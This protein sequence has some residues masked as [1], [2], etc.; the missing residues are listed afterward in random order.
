[1]ELRSGPAKI[2]AAANHPGGEDD[3]LRRFFTEFLDQSEYDEFRRVESLLVS[4]RSRGVNQAGHPL[5]RPRDCNLITKALAQIFERAKPAFRVGDARITERFERAIREFTDFCASVYPSEASSALALH[6][7][8]LLF[9]GRYSEALDVVEHWVERPYALESTDHILALVE[10]YCQARLR[11]GTLAE[12]KISFIALAEWLAKSSRSH[13]S[14][15][16]ASKLAPYMRFGPR[17]GGK[18]AGLRSRVIR[19]ASRQMLA[20]MRTFPQPHRF[21]IA[22]LLRHFWIAVSA[23]CLAL[24]PSSVRL[25]SPYSSRMNPDGSTLVA[26]AMGGIG[27]LLMMEPGLEALASAQGR[28][29]DFAIPRKFFP[30]FKG[31]PHVRLIDVHGP[32][33]DIS[34]YRQFVNLSNCPASIYESAARPFITRSRVEVF[35]RAM[36]ISKRALRRQGWRINQFPQEDDQAFCRKF[37]REKDFGRRPLVGVQPFSRDS[38][39]DYPAMGQVIS[40]LAHHYDVLI[41]HHVEADLP[42]GPGI[43]TVAGHSLEQ[44]L[45]LLGQLDAM[46]SVDSAFLHAAAAYDYPVIALFGPTDGRPLTSHHRN[47]IVLSKGEAFACVP[48]WRNEDTPCSVTELRSGKLPVSLM[49]NW[50][51]VGESLV[52]ANSV[53]ACVAAIRPDEVIAAVR[54]ALTPKA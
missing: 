52:T 41:F 12:S 45:A 40:G 19:F 38:Y 20:S 51:E 13:N 2:A 3:L 21:A 44:S 34:S 18:C 53:S 29:V 4:L 30:I 16:L 27:D 54:V 31:N 42:K 24:A 46:V 25:R 11:L 43:A 32:A 15:S 1:M 7:Q 39:K 26:R 48:C 17:S 23:V 9:M 35:S 28:P 22:F 37:L 5:V 36:T 6:G 10:V 33:I 47:P 14:V 49:R 50:G 8:V